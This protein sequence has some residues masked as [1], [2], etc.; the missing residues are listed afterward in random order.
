MVNDGSD[1]EVESSVHISKSSLTSSFSL[2]G[3]PPSPPPGYFGRKILGF[4]GLRGYRVC[5][6]FITKG[7]LAK[8]SLSIS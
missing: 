3:V 2:S 4:N 5:K 1:P 7:L 6:I 8:Y